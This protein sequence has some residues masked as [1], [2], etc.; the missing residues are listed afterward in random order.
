MSALTELTAQHFKGPEYHGDH[1]TCDLPRK[2]DR[3]WVKSKETKGL[4]FHKLVE[5]YATVKLHYHYD[6][7]SIQLE[8][9]D[10]SDAVVFPDMGD[11][12]VPID[13]GPP[14]VLDRA[15]AIYRSQHQ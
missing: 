3:V 2:G 12:I 11:D 4:R 13:S 9:D 1:I 7:C 6:G 10:G 8:M 14:S 15:A 5:G